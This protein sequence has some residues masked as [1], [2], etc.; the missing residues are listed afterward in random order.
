M[1]KV[2]EKNAGFF[3]IDVSALYPLII[4]GNLNLAL[5]R[6]FIIPDLAKYEIG[7]AVRFDQKIKAK[8]ELTDKLEHI[9]SFMNTVAAGELAKIQELALKHNITFYDAVYVFIA[10]NGNLKL[11]TMDKELLNKFEDF[12]I[13]IVSFKK[14]LVEL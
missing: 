2:S 13:D 8:I 9:I 11:V 5:L 4:E 14:I 3:V 12:A 7:N 10:L 1:D 6:R